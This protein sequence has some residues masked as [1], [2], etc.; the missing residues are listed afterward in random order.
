MLED[1][2]IRCLEK[3]LYVPAILFDDGHWYN[4]WCVR[5]NTGE[6]MTHFQLKKKYVFTKSKAKE[7][8]PSYG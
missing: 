4:L 5:L 2:F 1:V 3:E 7:K 6:P 8:I